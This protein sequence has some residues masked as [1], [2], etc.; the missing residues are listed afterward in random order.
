[1]TNCART[2]YNKTKPLDHNP[3]WQPAMNSSTIQPHTDS[4]PGDLLSPALPEQGVSWLLSLVAHMLLFLIAA[5]LWA[6]PPRGAATQADRTGG[7]VLV[8]LSESQPQYE[9][10]DESASE[11]DPLTQFADPNSSPPAD[12]DFPSATTPQDSPQA[13]S[14]A[15]ARGLPGPEAAPVQASRLLPTRE[16]ETGT[17]KAS[18]G[19]VPGATELL[20]SATVPGATRPG[21]KGLGKAAQTYLFGVP[22]TGRQFLYVF[23]RSSSMTAFSGRPFTAAKRE[24]AKSLRHLE[25]THQFQIIFYNHRTIVYNPLYPQ[26]PRMMFGSDDNKQRAEQWARGLSADGGT[27]HMAALKLAL[28][29]G[30]DVVFFLT[31]A[32]DPQLTEGELAK[33]TRLNRGS[34]INTIEFGS[35]PSRGGNFLV[36][37]AK[38]NGG[39]HAYVDVT[40]LP[41]DE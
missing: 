15:A 12:A 18:G 35:G 2:A 17:L 31:D 37:L 39:Q 21:G 32:D 5:I 16:S 10:L 19:G 7:I 28:G 25:S 14:V 1:M 33:I 8:D 3:I 13:N 23:D 34:V 29:L 9:L 20:G 38:L 11:L 22:G 36:R 24:L 30:P 41:A 26:P 6:A 40:Q 4:D 27:D